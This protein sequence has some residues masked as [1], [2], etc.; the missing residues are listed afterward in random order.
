MLASSSGP[1]IRTLADGSQHEAPSGDREEDLIHSA[2]DEA[3][4]LR[5]HRS[6][7]SRH[8]GRDRRQTGSFTHSELWSVDRANN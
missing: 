5:L 8:V 3:P 1:E 4:R 2:G 6:D 7:G